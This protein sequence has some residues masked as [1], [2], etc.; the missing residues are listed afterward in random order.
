MVYD[1]AFTDGCSLRASVDLE[2]SALADTGRLPFKLLQ[3]LAGHQLEGL[4]FLALLTI[5]GKWLVAILNF[6]FCVAASDC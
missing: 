6:L 1:E 5:Y 3:I 2:V 4:D